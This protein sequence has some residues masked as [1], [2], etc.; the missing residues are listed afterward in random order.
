M[1]KRNEVGESRGKLNE[2]AVPNGKGDLRFSGTPSAYRG[3]EPFITK[4]DTNHS[5]DHM[6]NGGDFHH[7]SGVDSGGSFKF[8]GMRGYG[9]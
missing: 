9:R 7:F 2:R 1:R 4:D 3:H 5:K 8:K 6:G